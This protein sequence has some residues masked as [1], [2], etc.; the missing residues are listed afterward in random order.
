MAAFK[1]GEI[2]IINIRDSIHYNKECLILAVNS[3]GRRWSRD[4]SSYRTGSRYAVEVDGGIRRSIAPPHYPLAYFADELRKKH[5]PSEPCSDDFF[6]DFKRMIKIK[7]P[8]REK[9]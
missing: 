1:V 3:E 9:A 8:K 5:P 7:E 2:A 6:E 4:M